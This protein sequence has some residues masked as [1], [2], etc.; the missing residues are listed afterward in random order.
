MSKWWKDKFLNTAQLADGIL[1][2]YTSWTRIIETT[3]GKCPINTYQRWSKWL[4]SL[5]TGCAYGSY[6]VSV[7]KRTPQLPWSS[8]IPYGL[9]IYPG[10]KGTA[11]GFVHCGGTFRTPTH[12]G[13]NI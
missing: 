7:L 11:M 1:L 10:F 12:Y 9:L 13:A 3:S 8:D 2:A 4:V 5:A 6:M